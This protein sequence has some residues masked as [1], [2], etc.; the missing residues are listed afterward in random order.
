MQ[1]KSIYAHFRF[2]RHKFGY[3]FDYYWTAYTFS[4]R[5]GNPIDIFFW[6]LKKI[7]NRTA[8]PKWIT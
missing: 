3:V 1:A 4:L 2:V 7:K 5:M 8:T 6:K